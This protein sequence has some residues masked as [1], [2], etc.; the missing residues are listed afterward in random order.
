MK[1]PVSAIRLPNRPGR[2]YKSRFDREQSMLRMLAM[3][4]ASVILASMVT[5][6]PV[7]S[8]GPLLPPFGLLMFLSWRLMRPGLWPIWSGVPFGLMDDL[9]SGQPF[10]SAGLL[11]SLAMLIVEIIDSRAIWRDYLQDWLIAALLIMAVLLGGLWIAGIAHAAPEPMV[12]FPQIILSIL[13]Y[14]LVVRI[15]AR[16]DRW[17][18]AT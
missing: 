11:W 13:L 5:T 1:I 4:I 6:L 2:E 12:L 18:L 8:A 3:P 17:R 15:C 9:F 16:L 10:G 7:F 14:P